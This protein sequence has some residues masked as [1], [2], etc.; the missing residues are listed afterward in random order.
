LTT[1]VFY[2]PDVSSESDRQGIVVQLPFCSSPTALP[3][4]FRL[5]RGKGTASQVEL[6]A[7]M[8]KLLVAA[9]PGRLVRGVGDAAFHGRALV[10]EGATWTTRLPANAA[11]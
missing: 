3:V 10:I 2:E 4:L 1:E 5:W 9:L 8:V 11:L 7:Q 6:A